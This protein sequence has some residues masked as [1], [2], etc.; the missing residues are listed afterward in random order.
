VSHKVKL[1]EGAAYHSN[2]L[3]T[4]SSYILL[5]SINIYRHI[6]DLYVMKEAAKITNL[7]AYGMEINA[8]FL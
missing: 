5:T 6:S 7:K 4:S 3:Q 1:P 8:T 2:T